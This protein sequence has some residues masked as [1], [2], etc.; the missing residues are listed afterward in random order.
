[1]TDFR[2]WK[3]PTGPTTQAMQ[4][5]F[6][7][8]GLSPTSIARNIRLL[9]S[10]IDR[11]PQL[12]PARSR[13]R[14]SNAASRLCEIARQQLCPSQQRSS[15]QQHPA[16]TPDKTQV[17]YS[18]F[19]QPFDEKRELSPRPRVIPVGA[20]HLANGFPRQG[21]AILDVMQA[22][23]SLKGCMGLGKCSDAAVDQRHGGADGQPK[24]APTFKGTI[25]F[26]LPHG[27]SVPIRWSKSVAAM[28]WRGIDL[29]QCQTEAIAKQ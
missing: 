11:L 21:A 24:T 12:Q 28:R 22:T 15:G 13:A 19:P 5:R 20:Q 17:G 25:A 9:V 23:P 29:D 1:V 3:P 4:S 8:V 10:Y 18:S 27:R 2:V 6:S 14:A 7:A 16:A 26:G